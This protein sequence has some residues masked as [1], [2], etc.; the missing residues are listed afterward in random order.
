MSVYQLVVNGQV[1][2]GPQVR[3]IHH[4]EFPGYVPDQTQLEEFVDAVDAAYKSNL[5]A[6]FWDNTA[7]NN[8]TVRRVD[9]GDLPSQD[10]TPTAGSWDGSDS[11]HKMPNQLAAMGTFKAPTVFPRSSRTYFFPFTEQWNASGGTIDSSL[12]AAIAAWADDMFTISITGDPDAVKVAVEYTGD[13]RVVS[14]YNTLT[15]FTI[16]NL[17]RTQ[18]RRIAGVGI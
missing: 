4:Y 15:S 11:N 12:L 9:S 1:G 6:Y 14:D 5:Q 7:F 16:E 10:I 8:Y 18:R 3:N 13:P 17:W 2:S